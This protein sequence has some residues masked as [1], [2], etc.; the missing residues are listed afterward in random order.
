MGQIRHRYFLN[1]T[2]ILTGIRFIAKVLTVM[3][4]ASM[5][6]ALIFDVSDNKKTLNPFELPASESFLAIVFYISILGLL[7]AWFWE[8]FGGFLTIAALLLFSL[9]YYFT[10]GTVLWKIWMLAIPACLYIYCWWATN[11]STT[12]NVYRE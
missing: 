2:N 3:I 9:F 5:I 7:L 1:S 10:T 12:F 8:S 6:I 4:L 11:I